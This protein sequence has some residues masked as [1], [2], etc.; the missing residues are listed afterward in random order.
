MYSGVIRSCGGGGRRVFVPLLHPV[1]F[2]RVHP[3]VVADGK[4]ELF[5]V[6]PNVTPELAISTRSQSGKGKGG[7]QFK[8]TCMH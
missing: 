1:R 5:S 2:I 3:E 4:T 7:P 8:I 6:K